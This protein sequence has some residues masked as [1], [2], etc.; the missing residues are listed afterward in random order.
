MR[1][2]VVEDDPL[3]CDVLRDFLRELG[4]EPVVTHSAEDALTR[5]GLELPD[6]VL[7]D[8][9]LPGISGLDFLQLQTTR[10][11]RIPVVAIS[12]MAA[13]SQA[14]EC[15]QLGAVD[16]LPKPVELERLREVLTCLEPHAGRRSPTAHRHE[17]RRAPRAVVAVPVRVVEDGG[18]EWE[19]TS[20]DLS[21]VGVKLCSSRAVSPARAAKLSF[22]LPDGDGT[23]EVSAMLVRSDG[24][25]YA[26]DF[27]S[28]TD[29][30][31]GR[32]REFV[33]R[34]GGGGARAVESHFRV[35]RAISRALSLS[36][37][38]DQMLRIALDALTRVTG[39]EISSLHFLS[40]DRKTLRL[41]ADRGLG[42]E[43]REANRVVAVGQG[44]IGRVAVTG[45]TVHVT[46]VA[47]C[48]E[49]PPAERAVVER[50]GIRSFVCVPLQSRGRILGALSLARRTPEPFT[51][52]EIALLEAAANQISLALDNAR[53]YSETRSQL[54]ELK[55]AETQRAEGE[56]LSTVGKLA[57][58]LVHEITNPLTVVLGQAELVMGELADSTRGRERV[59]I[60]IQETS[61]AARL[62]QKV[63]QLAQPQPSERRP[64]AL[65]DQVQWVVELKRHELDRDG[66]RIVTELAPVSSVYADQD[67][68]RQVLLN[69]VQ[70]AHQA[71][72]KHPGPRVLTLSTAEANGRVRVEVRDTGPGIPPELL[73]RIFDAFFTTKPPGEGT[74]LGLW[75]SYSIVE[76]HQGRLSCESR[77]DGGATFIVELPYRKKPR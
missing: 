22:A 8:I 68:I 28:P 45:E 26:F 54:D 60:I 29:S 61:R 58:G 35:L 15:V 56:R 76:Q 42:A 37:D 27:V 13:E 11:S 63:L 31:R 40:D 24:R 25:G 7:L 72:A 74:G 20:V 64:C 66:I 16:F 55:Q 70:N 53:L 9:Y 77:P 52:A 43:L 32:L 67:Q 38:V 1:V 23:L 21:A 75:V 44:V 6:A 30:E 33:Q 19:A 10:E 18:T 14:H 62:L 57:A 69:L 73:P 49:L 51:D 3:L 59:R 39:H 41:L 34:R 5:M 46:H 4:H 12:G 17:R 50:E 47:A 36:L 48:A 71:L 2:L 65:E